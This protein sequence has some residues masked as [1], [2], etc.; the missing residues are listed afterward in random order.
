MTAIAFLKKV[1]HP[2]GSPTPTVACPACDAPINVALEQ[3][4]Q[5][6]AAITVECRACGSTIETETEA[7]PVCKNTEYETFL[8]E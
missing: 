6:E 8:L 2:L 4:P 1:L 5:C 3:C 7:C